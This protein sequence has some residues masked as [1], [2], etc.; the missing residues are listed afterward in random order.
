MK[1]T[2]IE[3]VL[4]VSL[5]L[6]SLGGCSSS[7]SVSTSN[8]VSS[9]TSVSLTSSEEDTFEV[10]DLLNRKVT[11]TKSK[12]KR[13]VCIGAGALRLYTYV[14]DLD[15][16]SGIEDV[17]KSFLISIRPYQMVNES[18]WDSLPSCGKGG[19]SGSADAEKI[20]SCN[21]DIV[22]SLY[23]QSASAMDT[24]QSQI[25]KPV[26]TLSY[27]TNEAFD[28]NVKTSLTLM[29]RI[30][31]KEER[32]KEL[33]DYT[34]S[35]QEELNSKTKDVKKEDKPTIYLGCQ[36]NYGTKGFQ[37]ST[38]NYSI[39]DASNIRNVLDESI[40]YADKGYSA[41]IDLEK[42]VSINPDKI[43]LDAGGLSKLKNEDFANSE[44]KAAI[45]SLDAV[46]NGEVYLQMPYNAYYTNLE[47]AYM[48]AYYDAK[49]A[50]P[51]IFKDLD[52]EKK[53]NEISKKF[54]G[55]EI[56]SSSTITDTISSSMYGGF[57]KIDNLEEFI[58]DN[59]K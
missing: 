2:K 45:L 48:D 23:T 51:T 27:G 38:S 12:I 28:E 52:I 33:T 37:S 53:A 10:T 55:V 35:I 46:K 16:L 7:S 21:P 22:F 4:A 14:G 31:G 34:T 13:V 42:I 59:V 41:T 6:I 24:L 19:P 9:S 44:K 15:L 25:N 43:I 26:I 54:L 49:V 1:T 8:N 39:F 50:Y 3:K 57:Q 29:G 5:L 17:E 20:L 58:N 47:T 40:D 18:K 56:Y 36:S 32:A 11:V 30:L